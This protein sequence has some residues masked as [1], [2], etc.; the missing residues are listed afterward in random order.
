MKKT[1]LTLAGIIALGTT[2]LMADGSNIQVNNNVMAMDL[3]EVTLH[4]S[5]VGINVQTNE[6]H[7]QASGNTM[8]VSMSDTVLEHSTVG[9]NI[10]DNDK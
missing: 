5:T 2:T 4:E 3:A 1:I 10:V 6:S 8:A 9:I 7:V